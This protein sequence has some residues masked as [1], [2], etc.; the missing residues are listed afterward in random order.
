M[1]EISTQQNVDH[2]YPSNP[3]N[4]NS[5]RHGQKPACCLVCSF[6][7]LQKTAIAGPMEIVAKNAAL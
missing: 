6:G 4:S 2:Q 1:R 7:K 3:Q 5:Q